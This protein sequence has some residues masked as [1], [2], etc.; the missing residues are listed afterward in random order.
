MVFKGL[1]NGGGPTGRFGA[2]LSTGA[3][4]ACFS[5]MNLITLCIIDKLSWRRTDA[6]LKFIVKRLRRPYISQRNIPRSRRPAA[7]EQ[8]PKQGRPAQYQNRGAIK[9]CLGLLT[10]PS[11]WITSSRRWITNTIYPPATTRGGRNSSLR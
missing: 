7:D 11:L 10:A 8:T 6:Q 5:Q 2:A 3:V 9:I 1:E 4:S